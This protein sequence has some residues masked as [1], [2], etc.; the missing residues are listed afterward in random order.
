MSLLNHL[1][2]KNVEYTECLSYIT[3]II[4]GLFIFHHHTF[5]DENLERN[6]P[7]IQSSDL[8]ASTMYLS[9]AILETGLRLKTRK[10]ACVRKDISH[11]HFSSP[12]L[13]S[14]PSSPATL[15]AYNFCYCQ[16]LHYFKLQHK[17]PFIQVY[18]H[19]TTLFQILDLTHPPT[20]SKSPESS[21]TNVIFTYI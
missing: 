20:P 13:C 3:C 16:F 1:L 17:F 8:K 18:S 10:G 21:L 9:S 15:A 12:P 5:Q 7:F 11:Q 19:T 6:S 14:L 2:E 4:I